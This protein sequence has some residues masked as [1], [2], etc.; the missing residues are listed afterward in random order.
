MANAA[1]NGYKPN[2][3]IIESLDGKRIDI[4]NSIL[5]IDYFEVE[6]S[7][8]GPKK[9]REKMSQVVNEPSLPKRHY[10]KSIF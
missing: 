2:E 6:N 3:F 1:F 4:T 9:F 7:N 5:S 8:K 10:H